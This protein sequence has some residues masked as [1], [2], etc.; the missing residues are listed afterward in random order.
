MKWATHKKVT[1][2]EPSTLDKPKG[3]ILVVVYLIMQIPTLIKNQII[4]F[5]S[6]FMKMHSLLIQKC[7]FTLGSS[8]GIRCMIYHAIFSSLRYKARSKLQ[9]IICIIITNQNMSRV[10]ICTCG[11]GQSEI[12]FVHPILKVDIVSLTHT[13]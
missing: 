5:P 6:C 10:H 2:E 13:L 8:F 9:S 12:I 7:N 3:N 4:K 1:G 11:Y